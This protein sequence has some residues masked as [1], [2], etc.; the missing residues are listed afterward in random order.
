M[1]LFSFVRSHQFYGFPDIDRTQIKFYFIPMRSKIISRLRVL[2][3]AAFVIGSNSAMTPSSLGERAD[4]GVPGMI[5]DHNAPV[6]MTDGLQ[7]RV[8]IYRPDKPGQFPVLM[9]MGPYG[10]DTPYADAPAYNAEHP[11]R[12]PA[13]FNGTSTVA[14]GAGHASY[15]LLPHASPSN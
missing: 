5:F 6:T 14:T 13:L 8:N 3:V 10:K 7:L 11:N 9:L 12:D 4:S 1:A 15:L 2:A